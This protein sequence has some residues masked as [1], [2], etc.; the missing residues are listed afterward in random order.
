MTISRKKFLRRAAY[1]YDPHVLTVTRYDAAAG[2]APLAGVTASQITAFSA[3]AYPASAIAQTSS[4]LYDSLL[5]NIAVTPVSYA[6]P[7]GS[8]AGNGLVQVTITGAGTSE[9]EVLSTTLAP[10]QFTV[11][12]QYTPAPR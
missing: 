12:V 8:V 6:L 10:T 4:P 11:V 5:S 3:H 9:S 2:S 1:L 7:D